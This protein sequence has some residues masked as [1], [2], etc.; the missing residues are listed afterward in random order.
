L[1]N[2]TLTLQRHMQAT[3]K[4]KYCKWAVANGFTSMLPNDMKWQC[5]EAMSSLD[6][7][8]SLGGYL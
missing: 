8:P 4:A 7:Q 5:M 6:M 3:H 1:V 2:E